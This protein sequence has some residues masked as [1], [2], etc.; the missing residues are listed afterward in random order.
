MNIPPH[1]G[2]EIAASLFKCMNERG[3]E[4]K[5][6]MILVDN[7]SVNDMAIRLLRDD[8][9]RSKM[10]LC[11]GKLFHVWC[12]AYILNLFKMAVFEIMDSVNSIRESVELFNRPK[13]RLL[14]FAKIAE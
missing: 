13:S 1:K 8:F 5:I 3:I 11:G 2:I 4:H 10:L 9:S 14:L 6:H 12:Y 7:A